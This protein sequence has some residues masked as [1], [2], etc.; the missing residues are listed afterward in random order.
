V[1]AVVR[2]ARSGP[3]GVN[4]CPYVTDG[5]GRWRIALVHAGWLCLLA[6]AGLSLLGVYA[7]DLGMRTELETYPDGVRLASS[8]LA[9]EATSQLV[10][11]AI[12]VLAAAI[13]A[14]PHYRLIGYIAWPVMVI[15]TG[16]LIFLLIPFVPD[17]IVR[18]I[19]GARGWIN[20]RFFNLQ[21][22]ELAKIAF[23]LVAARYLR[24]RSTHRR[25]LGLIPVAAIAFVPMG[26]I[27]LQP[28]LGGALLFGP[29]L[30]AM[31]IAAGAKLRHLALVVIIAMLAVP[32]AFPFMMPHQQARIKA[33]IST[34]QGSREGAHDINYQAFTA[35]TLA[36][37]GQLIGHTDIHTRALVRF[38]RLPERHNDMIYSVITLRFGVVGA[39]AVL[40]LQM[41]WIAGALI[42]AA[43]CKDPFGRLVVVGLAGFIAAQVIVNIG[44]NIGLVP[45]I[46]VT[47]PF[48]SY[49][50]S[51]MLTVWI[52]TGLI[53]SIAMRRPV[54]PF[55]PSFEYDD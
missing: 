29:S 24:F 6:A 22:A 34:A 10:F 50:G 3:D 37:A 47:L 49:G 52:M 12:G 23:V 53:F 19:N 11:L 48:V 38:N 46:G 4:A 54:P 35:Q 43:V 45:V 30:F 17:T 26:L 31:L 36:G 15:T 25:L 18:P 39:M 27:T 1:S 16:L 14:L 33:L 7:I 42:T 9:R 28:D 41:M 21:P 20:L 5:A 13:V 8:T 44:M 2:R 51:S 40:L 32:A 55:R